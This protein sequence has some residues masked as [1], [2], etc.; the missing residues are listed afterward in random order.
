MRFCPGVLPGLSLVGLVG[1]GGVRT[2]IAA[3]SPHSKL[4]ARPL[5]ARHALDDVARKADDA[6]DLERAHGGGGVGVAEVLE[7]G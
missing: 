7:V 2:A 4:G 6:M 5:L 1:A 3:V